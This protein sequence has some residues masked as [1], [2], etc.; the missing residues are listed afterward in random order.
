MKNLIPDPDYEGFNGVYVGGKDIINAPPS[1]YD[2]P[3]VS[4]YLKDNNKSFND[5]SDDEKKQFKLN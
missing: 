3:A 1:N 4:K 2:F 5:L